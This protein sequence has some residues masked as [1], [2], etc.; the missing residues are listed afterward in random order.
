VRTRDQF[1]IGF[2][3]V[4][5][6]WLARLSGEFVWGERHDTANDRI[7]EG[8]YANLDFKLRPSDRIELEYRI[9][10]ST[11][12]AQGV[13]RPRAGSDRILNERV[14]RVLGVF[15]ASAQD[16]LRVI[17]QAA[18][19]KRS[20]DLYRFA[21]TSKDKSETLSLTFAHRRSLGTT[22]Y[23][24]ATFANEAEPESRYRRRQSEVF[25]KAS[26]ALNF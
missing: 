19:T 2:E 21:V 23:V 1:L 25:V 7:G 22:L 10:E 26:Y 9:D 18:F 13:D 3:S 17:Y 24:G 12:F 6:P 4:P 8:V 15:H 20:P 5:F 14:Q 11:I 16:S